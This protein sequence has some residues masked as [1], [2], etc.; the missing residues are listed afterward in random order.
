MGLLTFALGPLVV[1]CHL[2]TGTA[3]ATLDVKALI[4][5]ATVENSLVAANVGGDVVEGLDEA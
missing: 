3:E 5:F 4:L 2:E 1:V